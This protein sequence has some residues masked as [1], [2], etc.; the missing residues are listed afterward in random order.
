[1][2][3]KRPYAKYDVGY[4][5]NPK[6]QALMDDH[7]RAVLLHQSCINYAVQH[8]TDGLVP[9]RIAMRIVCAE[10][11]DLELLFANGLLIDLGDRNVHVHDFL[12]HQR[13]AAA[14]KAVSQAG[15]KGATARWEKVRNANRIAEPNAEG[16]AEKEREIKES[17]SEVASDPD[18]PEI[19][20]LCQH[21]AARVREN[22]HKVTNE[23]GKSWT[24]PCRLMLDRD[25]YTAEQIRKAIDWSTADSFWSSNIRSMATLREKYTVLRAQA[26]TRPNAASA[27][28]EPKRFVPPYEGDPDDLDAYNAHYA[29]HRVAS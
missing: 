16:N 28:A 27:P 15:T 7:P 22:G 9:V 5:S 18:R 4:L 12:E 29:Q 8:A 10:Q 6:I 13:S 25:G 21:L 1:M 14:I 24:N 17:S 2:P 26:K 3:D 19:I 11:S 20:E 23:L